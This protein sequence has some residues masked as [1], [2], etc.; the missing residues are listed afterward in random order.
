MFKDSVLNPQ[1]I[2]DGFTLRSGASITLGA[3]SGA[4]LADR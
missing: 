3:H 1:A 4:M 2:R